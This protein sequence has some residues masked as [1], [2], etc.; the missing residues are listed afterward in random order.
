MEFMKPTH[1]FTDKEK[2]EFF[3][4]AIRANTQCAEE[5]KTFNL[6]KAKTVSL[7][8]DPEACE[9]PAKSFIDCFQKSRRAVK[10]EC[11]KKLEKAETCLLETDSC[12]D[13]IDALM[14]CEN[15]NEA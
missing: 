7:F 15:G 9:Q 1:S 3:V 8:V 10:P 13:K 12:S 2:A 4:A 11:G 5:R 6:C 14:Q